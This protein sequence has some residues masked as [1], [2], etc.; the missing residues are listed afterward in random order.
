MDGMNLSNFF[1]KIETMTKE[2][3]FLF[4]KIFYVYWCDRFDRVAVL[5]RLF[6]AG[7]LW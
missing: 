2:L 7:G 5:W 6:I 4:F 1:N 3:V